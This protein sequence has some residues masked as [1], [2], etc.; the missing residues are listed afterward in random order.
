MPNFASLSCFY[1]KLRWGAFL[2]PIQN[3]VPEYPVQNRV[4]AKITVIPLDDRFVNVG[5][6]LPLA[7]M[8]TP[9]YLNSETLLT[10]LLSI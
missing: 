5:I 1:L 4:K 2:P 9:R 10:G 3:R 6:K 8:L 7:V